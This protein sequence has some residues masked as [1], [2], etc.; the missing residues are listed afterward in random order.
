MLARLAVFSIIAILL[1]SCATNEPIDEYEVDPRIAETHA[2]IQAL[3]LESLNYV[4]YAEPL[5]YEPI[6]MRYAI[7]ETNAGRFLLETKSLCRPLMA[8][9]PHS[10]MIDERRMR[11][12]LRTRADTLRGCRISAI[13]VL[14]PLEEAVENGAPEE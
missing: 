2:Y 7:L 11:G 4:R 10:D 14:P 8:G 6:N 5:R 12:R 1:S 13:Y 9:T 3:Q